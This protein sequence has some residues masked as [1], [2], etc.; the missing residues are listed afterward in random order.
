MTTLKEP[1][2]RCCFNFSVTAAYDNYVSFL[3]NFAPC[4]PGLLSG[5]RFE[6]FAV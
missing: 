6:L 4:I 2:L 5:I 3:K 1:D